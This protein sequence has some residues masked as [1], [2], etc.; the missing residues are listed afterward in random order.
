MLITSSQDNN[1][2]KQPHTSSLASSI[3]PIEID[4][5]KTQSNS[6]YAFMQLEL[7]QPSYILSST[8]SNIFEEIINRTGFTYLQIKTLLLTGCIYLIE[9]LQVSLSCLLFIPITSIYNTSTIISCVVSSS[10]LFFMAIGSFFT[11]YLTSIYQRRFI[12]TTCLL[13]TGIASFISC[14]QTIYILFLSRSVIGLSLGAIIPITTN[15]LAE[16]LPNKNRSFWLISDTIFFSVGAIIS[17]ELLYLLWPNMTV[18]FICLS[19]FS[20]A[21]YGVYLYMYTENPRYLILNGEHEKGFEII[22]TY[23]NDGKELDEAERTQ[24]IKSVDFGMNK[25]VKLIGKVQF[26]FKRYFKITSILTCIWVLYSIM[27]NGGVFHFFMGLIYTSSSSF[28]NDIQLFTNNKAAFHGFQVFYVLFGV[29]VLISGVITEIKVI[30]RK[31][32][33]LCGFVLATLISIYIASI[34]FNGGYYL[35]ACGACVINISVNAIHSYSVEVFPTRVRDFSVGYLQFISRICG[36]LSNVFVVAL[37]EYSTNWIFYLNVVIGVSGLV[38]TLLL[39]FDTY[40]RGLLDKAIDVEQKDKER[41][42]EEI[43]I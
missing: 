28:N 20:F 39:P 11:G 32:T 38:F 17:C 14:I 8:S 13:I 25:E 37:F 7:Q 19:L 26:I 1:N 31:Y 21:V 3:Q 35:Y 36:F 18:L 42:G 30:G 9:G 27:I 2:N 43:I 6:D 23:M 22:E 5:G 16:L 15:N 33:M 10:L 40:E 34:G 29:S 4:F 12:L 41:E 24:I